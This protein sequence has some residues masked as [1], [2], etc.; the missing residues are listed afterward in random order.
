LTRAPTLFER[1]GGEAGVAALV[2]AFYE[3]VL[4]DPELRPFFADTPMERLRTMQRAFFSAALDGPV[5]YDGRALAAAHHGRGIRPPHLR[6]FVDHLL[7]TLRSQGIG[8]ADALAIRD[9][10]ETYADEITGDT[11]VDA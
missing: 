10:I 5:V 9:R 1:I 3:R 11:S 7:A 6:R 8:E 4:A 2:Q